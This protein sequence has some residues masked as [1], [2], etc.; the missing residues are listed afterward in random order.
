M[1]FGDEV[2]FESLNGYKAIDIFKKLDLNLNTTI[3]HN[4]TFYSIVKLPKNVDAIEISNRVYE[5]GMV[6]F[7]HPNFNFSIEPCQLIPNDTYFNN[8][9]YLRNTGQIFNPAENHSGNSN[10][11]I[12]ATF[13]WYKTTGS[14]NIIVAVIDQG[15]SPDHPDLPSFRQ[16]RLNGSNFVPNENV[17]DPTPGSNMNHGNSCAGII[18]ATQNNGEG[19][20]GI[21]PGVKIMPI[22]IYGTS[23]SAYMEKIADA[24]DF[25]WQNGAHVISNSWSTLTSDPNASPVVV[26]AINRAVTQGR[27]G[28]GSVVVFSS[29]NNARRS[30]GDQ[31]TVTFPSNVQINGVL[32]V[33]ASDRMDLQGDYSPMSNPTVFGNQRID[34]VAPSNRA[35]PPEFYLSSGKQG[36]ISG[37][38]LEV[39]TIDIPGDNGNNSWHDASYPIVSPALGEVLPSGGTNNLAYTGRFGGTSAACPQVAGVA[40]LILSLNNA[41]TQ[42]EVFNI[43]TQS[44][45]HV[46]GY[47]Y[48]QDGWSNELGFGR[49]NACA[50]LARTPNS[51]SIN[52]LN[53]LCTGTASYSVAN[54]IPGSNIVWSCSNSSVATISAAGLLTKVGNGTVTIT[55]TIT[56]PGNRCLGVSSSSKQVRV[57]LFTNTDYYII[58]STSPPYCK[59]QIVQFGLGWW[60][61]N[62][63]SSY[64]WVWSG[65]TYV[66]GQGTRVL[67]LKIPYSVNG[68]NPTLSVG[69]SVGNSCGSSSFL[70]FSVYS[71]NPN[72]TSS[73]LYIIS[74]IP[75]FDNIK[76]E[77]ELVTKSGVINTYHGEIRE[78]QFI[79][80]FGA[81]KLD[82]KY[83]HNT[84]VVSIDVNHLQNDMYIVRIY[85]G[86]SWFTQN[87]LIRGSRF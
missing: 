38:G 17:N 81:L 37:E 22:K 19:I 45:D 36:G 50:A 85:D 77:S 61:V 13:A 20:S 76:I 65:A 24:I 75:A 10:A 49:L 78:V 82:R 11:D 87:I 40:A 31:G 46:G 58:P 54:T 66:S 69:L 63:A 25:A 41:L 68:S 2:I 83:G 70:P 86:V 28:L 27:G 3:I 18:A 59:N 51:Y 80:K 44:A 73:S 64:N 4:K 29:G 39:W 26:E 16:L 7:C 55:A 8:Q 56:V 42:Q 62:D 5:T 33:G 84:F 15:V 12:N 52:G 23:A 9:F 57:G 6:K 53:S 32:T 60:M 30:I 14:N 79:D 21:A 1:S 67:A 35:L 47:T 71:I 43:I 72:C 74:P 34:V 48:D